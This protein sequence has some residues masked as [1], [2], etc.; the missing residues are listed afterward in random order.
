MVTGVTYTIWF[1]M[2]KRIAPS[3]VA[4]LT[5][6]QPVITTTLSVLLL[7]EVIGVTLITG[8][9]L[10]IGGVLLDAS[11]RPD[12]RRPQLFRS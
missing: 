6:P 12:P 3:Q 10:V 4:I 9:L 11:P 7:H 5:T 8:G 2:L 1:A